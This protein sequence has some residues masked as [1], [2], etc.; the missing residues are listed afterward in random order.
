MDLRNTYCPYCG[1]PA[2]SHC[3]HVFDIEARGVSVAQQIWG[4]Y[5]VEVRLDC[6]DAIAYKVI[7][8]VGLLR[9]G[10]EETLVRL[11]SLYTAGLG[12]SIPQMVD[13]TMEAAFQEA[14]QRLLRTLNE[15]GQHFNHHRAHPR[16]VANH[17]RSFPCQLHGE[18]Y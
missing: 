8:T 1:A 7:I 3:E 9:E 14:A 16:A 13:S 4:D 11:G 6:S 5:S 10:D 12:L 17:P 15:I 2:E 18:I